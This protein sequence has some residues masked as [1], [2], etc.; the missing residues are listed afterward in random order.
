KRDVPGAVAGARL[1]DADVA[2]LVI[3]GDVYR[4]RAGRDLRRGRIRNARTAVDRILR[5]TRGIDPAVGVRRA[6]APLDD[7]E[8]FAGRDLDGLADC[9]TLRAIG[10]CRFGH[11]IRRWLDDRLADRADVELPAE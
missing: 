10:P 8:G 7:V 1:D 9:R 5:V 3:E 11:V 2:F 6:R 4:R